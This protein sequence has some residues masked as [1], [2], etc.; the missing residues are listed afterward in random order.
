MAGCKS[1]KRVTQNTER[2]IEEVVTTPN[3]PPTKKKSVVVNRSIVNSTEAYINMYQDAA[4][5]EMRIFKI[6]AS[7]KL[8][9]GILES[10]S[11][12]SE[13]TKKSNNHFGIKCHKGW[14]GGKVYHND[15]EKGECFR[16]YKDPM[17]S[18]RDHSVFLVGRERYSGLFKIKEGDYVR[19]A[20]GLSEAGYA[21]DRRYPAKLIAL[22]EKY[23]LDKFDAKVLGK[24]YKNEYKYKPTNHIVV[25]G[26][27]LYS[28]SKK[29]GLTV[30]E[31]KK[32]NGLKS[33]AIDIGQ[34]LILMN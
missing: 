32:M 29:Y 18:F 10:S 28:I 23:N 1:K 27:T 25:K 26:D 16:V 34:T 30:D 5:E 4:M 13:L 19:W 24:S 14:K 15:D 3:E 8:A 12:N 17:T 11:G 20:K 31:L 21:T 9:Q 7:I 2:K 33:N 22:I 6:P